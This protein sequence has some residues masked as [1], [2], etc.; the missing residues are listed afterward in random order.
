MRVTSLSTE[1]HRVIVLDDGSKVQGGASVTV[2]I[3]PDDDVNV[4][5]TLAVEEVNKGLR[6]QLG[7]S[8]PPEHPEA[9]P[10]RRETVAAAREL[11]RQQQTAKH[12]QQQK[13]REVLAARLAT[14][15]DMVAKARQQWNAWLVERDRA[16]AAGLPIPEAPTFAFNFD[17]RSELVPVLPAELMSETDP[18]STPLNGHARAAESQGGG[19]DDDV[20][21]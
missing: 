5:W 7:A 14:F 10:S 6:V 13:R 11:E 12:Q 3:A 2:E 4:A 16:V 21:F 8:L 18:Q 9:D 20:P 1:V 19:N 15:D 17:I